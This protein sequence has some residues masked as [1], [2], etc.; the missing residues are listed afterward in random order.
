MPLQMKDSYKKILFFILCSLMGMVFLYS[1]YT[2]LYP[3]EPFE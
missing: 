1:G 3:I 2:K